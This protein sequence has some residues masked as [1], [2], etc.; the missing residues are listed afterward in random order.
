[1]TVPQYEPWYPPSPPDLF[2]STSEEGK[3]LEPKGL[4]GKIRKAKELAL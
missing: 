3:A 2:E 4:T 1:M